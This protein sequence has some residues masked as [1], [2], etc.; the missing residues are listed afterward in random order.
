MLATI[1][2]EESKQA[3]AMDCYAEALAILKMLADRNRDTP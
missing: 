2:V 3:V 1:E